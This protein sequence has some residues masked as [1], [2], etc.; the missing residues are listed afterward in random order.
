MWI[1]SFW[2][3]GRGGSGGSGKDGVAGQGSRVEHIGRTPP[4]PL[5]FSFFGFPGNEITYLFS[6]FFELR[7]FVVTYGGLE[8]SNLSVFGFF[9]PFFGGGG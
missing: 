9:P 2:E 7:F 4:P 1:F 3:G 6:F 5:F 8:V